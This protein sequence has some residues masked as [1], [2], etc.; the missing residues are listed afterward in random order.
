MRVIGPWLRLLVAVIP[1]VAAAQS[2]AP[3][4][5]PIQPNDF[6]RIRTVRDPQLSPDGAWV[7]YDVSTPDSATDKNVTHIFMA[8]WDGAQTLQL[9]ASAESEGSPRFSPDGRWIAFLS[10]RQEGKGSQVWLLDRRGGEAQRV[11]TFPDGVSDLAWSPDSKRLVLVASLDTAAKKDTSEK[12]TPKPIVITR[13][14]FK[15]DVE[16]YLTSSDDHLLLL[17]IASKK[18]DTLTT[19]RVDDSDPRWSPDGSGIA[20][21][22]AAIP[23][24]GT[25]DRSDIFVVD[26]KPGAAPRKLTTFIGVNGGP[27]AWSPDGKWIAYV[28]GDEPRYANYSVARIAVIASDGSAPARII[29]DRLDR[30]L[31]EPRFS[32]DGRAVFAIL[33]DDRMSVLARVEIGTGAV[34][35]LTDPRSAVDAY[36][37]GADGRA[38]IR[39]GTPMRP[40]EIFA[41]E[42]GAGSHA[43]ALSHQ[44]DSLFALLAIGPTEDFTSRSKDGTEV[45]GLLVHPAAAPAGKRLPLILY[46]HGGPNGQ[47]EYSF[48]IRRQ[49]FAAHGYAVLSVNYRGSSGRGAAYTRAI[50]G[51]WGN[52]E[53]MDLMGAVDEVVRSGV[54]DPARLGVG[55][56]SYG[57]ISTDYLIAS[58]TR[59]KG[60]VSG[61]GSALQLTMFGVD[62]YITQYELEIGA[63]WKNEKGWIRI[64]YP[65][66]HADRITTPTLFM[67]GASD[68]NVPL[69]GGEQMYQALRILGVPTELVIYPG[70]YHGL[71]RPSFNV[72]RLQR[73]V[74]WYD[75]YVKP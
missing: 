37:M 31:S 7:A 33:E 45:H 10:G 46:L 5:R 72:D 23:E 17:D 8:S 24:P 20:F 74:S 55:G 53:T 38:A 19:G 29:A 21:V 48:D 30:P 60:A 73:W 57:G 3:A 35:R 34:A 22:R 62:E 63:P 54:A 25:G 2:A 1:A 75:R 56:W 26:A 51:D 41:F 65:M 28:Q 6:Y 67:G 12:E 42:G 32:A 49:L 15:R 11:T 16:G 36:A 61:A 39:L 66:F 4:Q 68:F 9:T 64:S 43:R 18:I 50:Y 70:Q 59:F 13:H 27:P 47:D 44:N 52:K 71:T 69:V 40:G 58:T 14:Q